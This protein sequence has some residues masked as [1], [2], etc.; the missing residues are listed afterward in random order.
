M[1]FI[2]SPK[3][4]IFRDKPREKSQ[5]ELEELKQ[6]V[7][8]SDVGGRNSNSAFWSPWKDSSPQ[9]QLSRHKIIDAFVE[10][11][12]AF[13]D[14]VVT[15]FEFFNFE[16]HECQPVVKRLR[17]DTTNIVL[18]AMMGRYESATMEALHVFLRNIGNICS[19]IGVI[20]VDGVVYQF[21]FRDGQLE[22]HFK[23]AKS[24]WYL[25]PLSIKSFLESKLN[26]TERKDKEEEKKV[27]EAACAIKTIM[28]QKLWMPESESK[29]ES[30]SKSKTTEI[31]IKLTVGQ[32][33]TRHF[34]KLLTRRRLLSPITYLK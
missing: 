28:T 16:G 22:F 4:D 17:S 29:A 26:M 18:V 23:P 15:D 32:R 34:G 24:T 27:E 10:E 21:D 30:E 11:V 31:D 12:F 20:I 25:H 5:E 8:C 3:L 1:S 13:N 14:S 6:I 2:I 9:S 19:V 7:Q 33:I